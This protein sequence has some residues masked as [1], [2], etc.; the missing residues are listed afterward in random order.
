[1]K[2]PSPGRRIGSPDLFW[3]ACVFSLL[4]HVFLL[5]VPIVA[6]ESKSKPNRDRGL[7]VVLV[8][9]K[10]ARAPKDPQVLAQA[11][12]DGGGNVDQDRKPT[13][14]LPPQEQATEG[15]ALLEAKRRVEQLEARQRELLVQSQALHAA[16]VEQGK[17][18]E[19]AEPEPVHGLDLLD[20]ARAMARQQAIV[21][22]ALDDYAKRPRKMFIAP[23]AAEYRFA[24]YVEDWRHKVERIGTLNFPKA[25]DG[26]RLYG[27]VGIYL[28]IYQDGTLYIEPEIRQSSGNAELD[29]AALRILHLA[30][31]FAPFPP[32]I[33]KD[34]QVLQ[35]YRR[36]NF[37]K[38]E[39]LTSVGQNKQ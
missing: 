14:P 3:T 8:N 25:A 37:E 18:E 2:L 28:E 35:I 5:F 27:S 20:S 24:Q 36:W 26:S 10:H 31:P 21:D 29:R 30:A 1:L 33:R 32:E 6:P 15:A 17:K 39:T 34:A 38:G 19:A 12:L 11:N 4:L 23:R 13:T 7:D 9:A 22:K 16:Q